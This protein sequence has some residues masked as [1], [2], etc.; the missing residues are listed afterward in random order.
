MPRSEWGKTIVDSERWL[1]F[2]DMLDAASW[3]WFVSMI[4]VS[5]VLVVLL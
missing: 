5:L 2:T 4:A 3:L 1:A